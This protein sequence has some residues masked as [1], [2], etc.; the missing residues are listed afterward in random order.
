MK[1]N[2]EFIIQRYT[3]DHWLEL[4]GAV[5]FFVTGQGFKNFAI[6]HSLE[7]YKEWRFDPYLKRAMAS[8]FPTDGIHRA[9][10]HQDACAEFLLREYIVQAVWAVDQPEYPTDGRMD[11]AIHHL[12][13]QIPYDISVGVTEGVIEYLSGLSD[14]SHYRSLVSEDGLRLEGMVVV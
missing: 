3:R 5:P 12:A 8:L 2:R 10:Y 1:E 9:I 7:K 11:I 14:I 13:K 4:V 6:P